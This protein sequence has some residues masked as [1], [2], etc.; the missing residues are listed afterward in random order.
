MLF[1][2]FECICSSSCKWRSFVL[3]LVQK[4]HII[5]ARHLL[6]GSYIG[7][8]ISIF[9]NFSTI[10]PSTSYEKSTAVPYRIISYGMAWCLV[11]LL[12]AA[13]NEHFPR[14]KRK[15]RRAGGRWGAPEEKRKTLS[16]RLHHHTTAV[17]E[18]CRG[19]VS[20]CRLNAALLPSPVVQQRCDN[21]NCS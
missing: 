21:V 20:K 18:P 11:P 12:A 4:Y 16:Y 9:Q 14:Q 19:T 3:R 10:H 1:R 13:V 17:Y 8:K 5:P 7:S 6:Y 15:T 2:F